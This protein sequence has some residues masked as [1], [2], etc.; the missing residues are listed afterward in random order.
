M[1]LARGA[2]IGALGAAIVVL[3][4]VLLGGGSGHSYTL[5]FQTAGQLVTG[6][7][8]QVGGRGVGTVDSISLTKDNQAA[9]GVTVDDDFAPLHQGTTAVVRLTSLS[10]VANRYVQLTLGP[11][12]NPDIPDGGTIMP[13][14]TTSVVDLDQIFDTLN[15]PTRRGLSN[16]IKGNAD[17]YRGKVLEANLSAYYLNPALSTSADVFNQI[18]GDQTSFARA[19]TATSGAMAA[20]ASRRD[21][22][23]SSV[24]YANQFSGAIASENASFSQALLKLPPTLQR[25]NT[26]FVDLRAT[27][28]TL[29]Q[30]VDVSLPN[31]VGLPEFFG[32]LRPAAARAVPVISALA[33]IIH[34]P[35]ANNDL[36]DTF[37][38]APILQSLAN[39]NTHASFPESLRALQKGQATVQFA[40]PY[41]VDLVGWM[42]ELGQATALYDANGHY[43][44]VS[45]AYNAFKYDTGTK[46]LNVLNADQRL[47]IYDDPSFGGHGTGNLRRCPGAAASP[48]SGMSWPFLSGGAAGCDP[49]EVLPG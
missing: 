39:G 2:A 27:L 38:N 35:G 11:N 17:W 29:Q 7:E 23:S 12:S 1:T 33:T 30:L 15:A 24:Q 21:D 46:D 20:I 6:D 37:L 32:A 22:L 43:A 31:T 47:S 3:A 5:L 44:R 8:V 18:A 26:T 19:V 42:R 45:P 34:K 13:D 41:T 36:T 4:F 28:D 16:F 25:A 40:R 9:V 48:P 10:G 14:H 49:T